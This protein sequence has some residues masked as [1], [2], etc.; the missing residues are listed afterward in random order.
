MLDSEQDCEKII[1]QFQAVKSAID[2][3]YSEVLD[4]NFEKCLSQKDSDKMKKL[5]KLISKR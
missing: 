5:I 1:I 3:A 4:K 2:S